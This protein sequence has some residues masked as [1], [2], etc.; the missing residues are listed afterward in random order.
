MLTDIKTWLE[1]TGMKVAEVCFKK[2]PIFPY[3]CFLDNTETIGSDEKN[4]IADRNITI[5]L[6]DEKINKDTEKKITDLLDT[7]G[8]EYKR[9]STWVQ[10]EEMFETTFEFKFTEK[11]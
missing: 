5:E 11:I 9:D 10:T 8:I 1:T 4:Y 2:P 3:I 7:R 6:Y